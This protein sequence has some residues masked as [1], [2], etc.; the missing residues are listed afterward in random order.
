MVIL[1][2]DFHIALLRAH[3]YRFRLHSHAQRFSTEIMGHTACR[4]D[5]IFILFAPVKFECYL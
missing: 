3:V 2:S 5:N 4:D 1:T